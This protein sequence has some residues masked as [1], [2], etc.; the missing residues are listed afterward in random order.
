MCDPR[1]T[2]LLFHVAHANIASQLYFVAYQGRVFVYRPRSSLAQSLPQLPDLQLAPAQSNIGAAIGGFV[3]EANP[4]LIN[5]LVTGHL[6][7]KEIVVACYDDGDV[8][9][10]YVKDVAMRIAGCP[11]ETASLIG[12]SPQ[13]FFHDNVG[14][15][16]WGLA[17]HQKSRLLAVSS[18]RHEVTVFAFG[19]DQKNTES[20]KP[21]ARSRPEE[22]D[23]NVRRRTRNWRI[24]VLMSPECDNI[25]NISF[26]DDSDGHAE[27]IC[28]IDI[29]GAIW[30]AEI[31]KPHQ[32]PTYIAP[33]PPTM[34]MSEESLHTRSR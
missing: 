12:T 21:S 6:G 4:H 30:L 14:H 23:V 33:L 5:H 32:P 3:D 18:N 17:V 13:E 22:P 7:K 15:T 1:L 19:L 16:A 28:A 2:L 34:I 11:N 29:S 25:P 9:A 31:W 27:K 8:V 26:V 20:K 24:I 10:Y